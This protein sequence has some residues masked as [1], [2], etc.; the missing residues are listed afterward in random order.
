MIGIPVW[1]FTTTTYRAALPFDEIE[2]ISTIQNFQIDIKLNLIHFNSEIK[3][4][5][6]AKLKQDIEAVLNADQ[7]SYGLMFNFIVSDIRYFN[8]LELSTVQKTSSLIEFD[9]SLGD[10]NGETLKVYVFDSKLSLKYKINQND[11]AFLNNLYLNENDLKGNNFD[12]ICYL[13]HKFKYNFI[14]L[15]KISQY[16]QHS[17]LNVNQFH[18]SYDSKLN[19]KRKMVLNLNKF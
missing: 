2:K 6:L 12:K 4:E 14:D 13:F 1:F 10:F 8:A 5:A 3:H 16:L 17:Y 11:F 15:Y 7:M 9:K 18:D 19:I